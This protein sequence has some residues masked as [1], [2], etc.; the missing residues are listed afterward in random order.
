ME[1]ELCGTL[2]GEQGG[3]MAWLEERIIFEECA[4]KQQIWKPLN[5]C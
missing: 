5:Y 3:H 2:S 1:E 4:V